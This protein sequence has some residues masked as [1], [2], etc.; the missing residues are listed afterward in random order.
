MSLLRQAT[1]Y[2][3]A[4]KYLLALT[5][6]Q[7]DSGPKARAE[8]IQSLIWLGRHQE[9]L[10][11]ACCEED[12]DSEIPVELILARSAALVC[13]GQ[14]TEAEKCSQQAY[15][16]SIAEGMPT[17]LRIRALMSRSASRAARGSSATRSSAP[18]S[19]PP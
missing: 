12:L 4:G 6:A 19:S 5:C 8:A 14:Y 13:S 10:Q 1:E 2:R 15:E 9:A 11:L 17:I 3:E 16:L 18:P 7:A